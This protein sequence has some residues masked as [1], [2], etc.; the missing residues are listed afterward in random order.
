MQF[1]GSKGL[2]GSWH[3]L[4]LLVWWSEKVPKIFPKWWF[5]GDLS[6]QRVKKLQLNKQKL[7]DSKM[8]VT[9]RRVSG[10]KLVDGE[11]SLFVCLLVVTVQDCIHI[12]KS[13]YKS[14]QNESSSA[15][16][17]DSKWPF[18]LLFGGHFR[19]ELPGICVCAFLPSLEAKKTEDL[20]SDL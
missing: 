3:R 20:Y 2:C 18:D 9:L 15:I 6:S 1:W 16:P 12:L 13:R 7:V 19:K 8:W 4:D 17:V 10:Q 5:N 14:S 11:A